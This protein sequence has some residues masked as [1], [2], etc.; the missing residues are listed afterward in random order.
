MRVDEFNGFGPQLRTLRQFIEAFQTLAS[1]V[2]DVIT[3]NPDVKQAR[4][5]L[6]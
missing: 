3:P 6:A 5:A 4:R 1:M 2:R